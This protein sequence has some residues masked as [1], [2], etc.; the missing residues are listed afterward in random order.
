MSAWHA[1]LAGLILCKPCVFVVM[2][3][4]HNYLNRKK[5]PAF[6]PPEP[7]SLLLLYAVVV[8]LVCLWGFLYANK[9]ASTTYTQKAQLTERREV[10]MRFHQSA[11]HTRHTRVNEE[12]VV[13]K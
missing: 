3:S 12:Y 6:T 1:R 10:R 2:M 11:H 7:V 8:A 5:N 9:H 4:K 13:D